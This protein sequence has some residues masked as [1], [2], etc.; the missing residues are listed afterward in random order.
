M[1]K[2]LRGRNI[3]LMATMLLLGQ[4][5]ATLL[6]SLFVIAPQ[7]QRVAGIVASN[8]RMVGATLDALPR[9]ERERFIARINASGTFRIRPGYGTPPGADG[10][11]SMLETLVLRTLATDLAQRENVVWRGGGRTQ[12]WVRLQLGRQGY[13][14][15]SLAPSP[16]WSPNGAL[17]GSVALALA[18]SLLTALILQQRINRPLTAL[19]AAVDAMPDTRRVKSLTNKAPVEIA[20]LAQ[21][22]EAMAA[23]LAEQEANRALMLAGISHDLKTPLTKIRLALALDPPGDPETITMLDRQLDRMQNML[24]QFLDFGRGVDSEPIAG[25]PV[26]SAVIAAITA[27][28]ADVAINWGDSSDRVQ[29]L[30]R[31]QGFERA[32]VNLIR[33]AYEHG[34]PPVT[35]NLTVGADQVRLTIT[36]SGAGIPGHLLHNATAPFT[37]GRAARP[38]DGGTGLGLAIVARFAREHGGSLQLANLQPRGFSATLC[39][40]MRYRREAA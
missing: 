12:L 22:F 3:V 4:L 28:E 33:N 9:D 18:L 16:G 24:G 37:R 35:I 6:I 1:L 25:V 32:I 15:I 29:V 13:F 5:I 11:P 21:S 36:D 40:P 23:R 30:V 20:R 7:A 27:T 19:S 14:W 38:S 39:L 26:Q 10:R 34:E 17:L 2:S 31:P 8:V